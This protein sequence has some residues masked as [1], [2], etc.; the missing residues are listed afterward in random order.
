MSRNLSSFGFMRIAAVTPEHKV[1]AIDFNTE[2]IL[3]SID[4]AVEQKCRIIL[5]PEL[6]VTGYTCADL[7]YQ[8]ILLDNTRTAINKITNY[9]KKKNVTV[10][11]G[12][13]VSN[14]GKLYNCA[15]LISSG[16]IKGIVP[17]TFLCNTNEY[18]EE[19][20]FSSEYDRE[21]DTI[22][23]NGAEVPF[24]ADLLFK[25]N[26]NSESVLGIEICEDLWSVIPPSFNMALA[27]ATILMNLS[28]GDEVMG[29]AKYRRELVTGQSARCLSAYI[30]AGCGPGESS[31][32]MVFSGH[33]IIAENGIIL[34]ESER[35]RFDSNMIISD[36][37]IEKLHQERI[38]NNSFGISLSEF[39]Y[40]TIN[41]NV[42]ELT[43]SELYRN[44]SKKPFIPE[45]ESLRSDTC[46]EIFSIQTAGLSKRLKFLSNP[47]VVIGVSGGLDSS[48]ALL[49]AVKTFQKLNLN[50]S[51]IYAVTM[52]GLGTGSRT[53]VNAQN[54]IE[55][56][57]VAHK[58]I[59]INE[60]VRKHFENIEH[61]INNFDTVYENS[62][63]RERMQILMDLANKYKG[64]VIGTGDLSELALGWSTYN[65]DHMS[66]YGVNAGVPKTLVRYIIE[67]AAK[68]E[69]IGEI[70]STLMDIINTPISPELI[71]E[72]ING[73]IQDTEKLIGPYALHDFF[74][75]YSV[76]FGFSPQKILLLANK[77][78]KGEF[79]IE[80]LKKFLKIF[81]GRF[82]AFQ[83]KRSC[84]PDGIK[85]GSVALSPRGDWRMPS[86]SLPDDWLKDIENFES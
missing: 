25:I 45:S 33:S 69:F 14:R 36:I 81:I 6:C 51:D 46:K 42:E 67:W 30:Y 65:G 64:I 53:N 28:A 18:Y 37:D 71:P 60:A 73:S 12:A 34:S 20:W 31:T 56:L 58:N 68:Y 3:S 21:N 48:L 35:F 43:A 23:L 70:S 76:R 2:Q 84:I 9:S 41:I 15:F 1:A 7:F 8:G 83:F 24:G 40:R 17:K 72:E 62:Q 26:N 57:G 52:P 29:K 39:E 47:P 27:G 75:Y 77:A 82:F 80:E 63:A 32:D 78:F 85:I 38:K 4:K 55:Q 86:D 11:V 50:L 5:F 54:L 13:P 10:V 16:D 22:E 49:V 74:L 44:I 59:S 79:S 66:M 19:R 61:D